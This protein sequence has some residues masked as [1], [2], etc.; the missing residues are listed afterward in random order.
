MKEQPGSSAVVNGIANDRYGIGYSG[1]GYKTADVKALAIDNGKG[2]VTAVPENA[3]N[4]NYSMARPLMLSFNYKPGSE[5]DP[6]RREFIRFILSQEGQRKVV[7]EGYLPISATL[8]DKQL[9]KVGLK[10]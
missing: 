8:A 3:Y 1:I 2:P 10:K 5:L 6:L 9:V 7:K 4:G